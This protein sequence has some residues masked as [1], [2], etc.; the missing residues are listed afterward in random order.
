MFELEAYAQETNEMTQV[1]ADNPDGIQPVT[2]SAGGGPYQFVMMMGVI[3]VI[4]YFLLIRPEKKK[5]EEQEQKVNSLKKGDKIIT[6]GGIYGSIV[7]VKDDI[8][9]IKIAENVKIE[10]LKTA[11]ST[12]VGDESK[13]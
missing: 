9:V 3:F 12:I 11:I 8:A 7:G 2:T 6:A 5:R 1:P 13:K 10:I 4:F